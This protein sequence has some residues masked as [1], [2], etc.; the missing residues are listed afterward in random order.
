MGLTWV[1]DPIVNGFWRR[2]HVALEGNICAERSAY[3]LVW[4]LNYW[5][6]CAGQI[7]YG[8]YNYAAVTYYAHADFY[9]DKNNK[10]EGKCFSFIFN[11]QL[12]SKILL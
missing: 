12:Q 8:K 5:V 6:N 4:H 3:Q 1:F 9:E 11:L 7:K 2:L 10:I